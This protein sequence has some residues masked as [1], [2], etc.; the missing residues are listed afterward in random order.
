MT[1]FG[2]KN[3]FWELLFSENVCNAKTFFKT[4]KTVGNSAKEAI[5]ARVINVRIMWVSNCR[6]P[7]GHVWY[8]I[9]VPRFSGQTFIFGVVFL[10]SKFL[11][12]IEG[13]KNLT[14]FQFWPESLG[15]MLEYWYIE[16][17]PVTHS[18]NWTPAWSRS[19]YVTNRRAGNHFVVATIYN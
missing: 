5:K 14:Y 18:S 3:V 17:W 13:Q 19:D 1:N 11:L 15:A 8:S 7:I 6:F 4:L 9:M 16:R 2:I 10:V 12:G